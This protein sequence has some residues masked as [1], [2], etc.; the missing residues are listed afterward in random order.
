MRL[1]RKARVVR[2]TRDE[3]NVLMTVFL[4]S[5][6]T[7]EKDDGKWPRRVHGE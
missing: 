5:K 4:Y 3:M 7:G 2:D 6:A 1:A